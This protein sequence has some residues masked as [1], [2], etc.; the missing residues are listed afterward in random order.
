M[1]TVRATGE[2]EGRVS[3]GGVRYSPAGRLPRISTAAFDFVVEEVA[4]ALSRSV[5]HEPSSCQR[6]YQRLRVLK[7]DFGRSGEYGAAR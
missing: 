7:W 2:P 1:S 4:V 5:L 6:L 3:L